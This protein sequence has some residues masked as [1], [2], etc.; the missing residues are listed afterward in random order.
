MAKD[1]HEIMKANLEADHDIVGDAIHLSVIHPKKLPA[2]Q[3]QMW[4]P[5]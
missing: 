5:N 2:Y 3:G 1:G 4:T